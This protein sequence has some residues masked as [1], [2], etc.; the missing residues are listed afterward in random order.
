MCSTTVECVLLLQNVFYYYRMCSTTTEETCLCGH[1]DLLT[2]RPTFMAKEA[3]LPKRPP[4][5]ETYWHDKRGLHTRRSKPV[6]VAELESLLT[7]RPAVKAKEAYLQKRPTHKAEQTCTCRR[8][9][10][11]G[12]AW[13]W[14]AESR[15]EKRH[16]LDVS[17]WRM[18]CPSPYVCVVC[19]KVSEWVWVWGREWVCVCVCVCA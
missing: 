3:Y 4:Y 10:C 5:K 2:K 18:A 6:L 8:T 19:G 9:R 7:K 1:R 16:V 12:V 11:A 17:P 14:Y 13:K 15:R